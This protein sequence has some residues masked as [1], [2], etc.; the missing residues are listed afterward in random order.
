MTIKQKLEKIL[1]KDYRVT[2][3]EMK[4]L[5]ELCDLYGTRLDKN[6]LY[7]LWTDWCEHK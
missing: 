6:E 7:N 1:E 5:Q 2:D 4:K 3:E